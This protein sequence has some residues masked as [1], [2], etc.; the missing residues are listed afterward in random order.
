[1]TQDTAGFLWVSTG[2]GL[3]RFDGL[4]FQPQL[5]AA[6]EPAARNL[7]WN[8]VLLAGRDG[9]VWI[10]TETMGLAV[11]D[12]RLASIRDVQ[13]R[14]TGARPSVLALA[15]DGKG[16]I[17]VGTAGGGLQRLDPAT[18]QITT[19][20]MASGSG[21][22]DD[23]I[24]ALSVDADGTLW[25]GSW[26]GLSR[27]RP[28][29]DTF[30]A[31]QA[32][33][34]AV[35][36][37][38]V[39]S[40]LLASGDGRLWVGT[41]Q[42]ELWRL[43][44][45]AQQAE[46]LDTGTAQANPAGNVTALLQAADGAV[47]VGRSSGLDIHDGGSGRR[48][49]SL[50]QDERRPGGL[51]AGQVSAL[52][53]DH[54]GAVWVGGY[55]LGLQ[56]HNPANVALRV[57]DPTAG[58]ADPAQGS[59]VRSLLQLD[60]GDIWLAAP[61][62]GIRLLSP[63]LQANGPAR[64]QRPAQWPTAPIE[65]MAQAADGTVWLAVAGELLQSDRERRLLRRVAVGAGRAHRVVATRDGIIWVCTQD[66]L[67][68]VAEG[69]PVT[70]RIAGADG[71]PFV[72]DVFSAVEAGDGG[73]WVGTLRGL[74]RLPR[75]AVELQPVPAEPGAGLSSAVV[76]GLLLD[77]HGILWLDTAIG[78]LHRM[79]TW[80]GKAA[81]FERISERH[82]IVGP[83]FGVNLLE[84]RR[85]RI[86]TQQ[87]VYDPTDDRIDELGEADGKHF[88]TGWFHAYA[89]LQDSR[90]VFGG[91]RGL[92]V[93]RP[94]A[95]APVNHAAP[96]RVLA[97]RIDGVAQPAPPRLQEVRL[98]AGQRN[99]SLEF[100]AIDYGD[101]TRIHYAH[102]LEGHD[103]DWIRT[104][105]DERTASY[106]QLAPGSYLLRVRARDRSGTWNPHELEIGIHVPAAWWQEPS[107][108]AGLAALLLLAVWGLVHWRTR[109]LQRA[110]QALELKVQERT[111]ALQEASM[112]DP[113]T[114]LRNRRFLNEH[115]AADVALAVRRH[116][117]GRQVGRPSDEDSDLL[118]FVLDIDHFK[119]VNDQHGHAAGDAVLR[120]VQTRLRPVFRD[121]DHLVRWGGEEFLIVA[122]ATSRR[123][124]SELA[125]RAC[126]AIAAA[127]FDLGDGLQMV[128]SC[129][130][131]FAC[132]PLSP[133]HPRAFDWSETIGLA[134]AALYAAKREGRHRWVGVL[135]AGGLGAPAL[136][137]QRSAEEWLGSGEL[138]VLRS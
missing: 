14:S 117:Q 56:R 102:R 135:D 8:R 124:A 133:E 43:D 57:V 85:G 28:D 1:M 65:A 73:L 105:A 50:Q 103:A 109:Q 27:L 128:R 11:Y 89:R 52:L 137:R 12:P 95:Y 67:F 23:R 29:S 6:D 39:V 125:D 5:R 138:T 113:L 115:I 69:R 22:P 16:A 51:A 46:R 3:V 76:H 91:S 112:T 58:S 2:D 77:S 121:A 90:F 106:G 44:A 10:G 101:P 31:V 111:A 116:E 71:N 26:Q 134:D 92:L 131:G 107:L 88:G 35:L 74:F 132:F 120:Q 53:L 83:P 19:H 32:A 126:R 127:P 72:G 20:T 49:Q 110:R 66:G 94:D 100:A 86:W 68:R 136:A 42:G 25:V 41:Q 24:T 96:L 98:H 78:G 17:W 33:P 15:E 79:L 108:R 87:Y 40:S 36:A 129:S 114:G 70:Q 48:L 18:G 13:P 99:F 61:E 4:R 60:R 30:E 93:V 80:D 123:H 104:G 130:L 21:L 75:G 122:R 82:G 47:W 63:G 54:N 119:E 34:S 81:R 59:S 118:F 37:G 7:G 45:A 97:L 62:G 9:R 38:K 55:G 84:D 64:P